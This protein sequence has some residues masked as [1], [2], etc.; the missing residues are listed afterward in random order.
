MLMPVAEMEMQKERDIKRIQKTERERDRGMQRVS[1]IE[2]GIIIK[3][4]I[5]ALGQY[6][7]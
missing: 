6:P 2:R 5:F 4:M 7:H 1:E 3:Y